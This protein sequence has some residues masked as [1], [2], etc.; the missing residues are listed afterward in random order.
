MKKKVILISI[1]LLVI[2]L[3]FFPFTQQQSVSVKASFFN[4]YQQLA[5]G[6]NWIQWRNDLRAANSSD[7][8]KVI[9]KQHLNNFVISYGDNS[10]SVNTINGYTFSIAEQNSN[11]Y[12]YTLIPEK[13]TNITTVMVTE[14]TNGLKLLLE[15][16]TNHNI[17][18][19]HIADF[20][21]FMEDPDLYYGYKIIKKR[22]T[23]TCIIVLKKAVLSKNKFNEA[24]KTLGTLKQFIYA[25][26]LQQTQ[27]L[28]AQFFPKNN[29]STHVNIGLPINKKTTTNKL[30]SFMEMPAS[31]S[32]Y[33]VRFHG[34]FADRLKVYAAVRRYFNDRNLAMPILPFETYLDNKLPENDL[35]II[36]IQINFTTY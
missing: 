29:D 2:L 16:I 28:I 12:S 9:C 18:Q 25:K 19:N 34:K 15:L 4:A 20:K 31:G 6:E 35:D 8:T 26:G 30:I 13:A 7:K 32:I 33:T 3:F 22:V 1:L 11:E 5:V 21:N 36:N 10:L 23:D 24:A 27:P 14:K 17:S